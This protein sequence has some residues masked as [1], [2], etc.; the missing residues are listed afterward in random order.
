MDVKY[1]VTT[2]G[3]TPDIL[4]DGQLL[5]V[6]GIA[7]SIHELRDYRRYN[8]ENE[9]DDTIIGQ[10]SLEIAREAIDEAIERLVTLACET[11]ISYGDSNECDEE[12]ENIEC[13][14][15]REALCQYIMET[16]FPKDEE[17]SV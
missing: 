16:L 4:S 13:I 7:D 8:I 12:F 10:M 6:Y 5:E 3:Y 17:E 15:N 2:K 14:G 9:Y 11:M 1:L